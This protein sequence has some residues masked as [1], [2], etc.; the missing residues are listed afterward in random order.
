MG[1]AVEEAGL[2]GILCRSTMDCGDGLPLK[3]QETTEESLQNK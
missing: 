2:R 3:W 1:K